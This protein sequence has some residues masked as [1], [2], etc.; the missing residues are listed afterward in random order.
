M[1]SRPE[2]AGEQIRLGQV[3]QLGSELA[4]TAMEGRFRVAIISSAQRLNPD[5]QNALLE[6]P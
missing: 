6:D 5:A 1:P 4:L 3:Q 2:G